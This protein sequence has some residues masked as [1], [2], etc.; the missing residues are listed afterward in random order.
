VN[1]DKFEELGDLATNEPV[2]F[3]ELSLKRTNTIKDP[4]KTKQPNMQL[5]NL[6]NQ[7]PTK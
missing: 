7:F 4:E 3:N 1:V 5:W 2:T 6:I